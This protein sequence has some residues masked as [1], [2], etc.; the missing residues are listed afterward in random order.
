VVGCPIC[1]FYSWHIQGISFSFDLKV[2]PLEHFDMVLGYDWLIQ[3]RP[4]KV[5][6]GSKWLV[7]PYVCSTI[8]L[9]GL[10]SQL[11]AGDMVQLY[12]LTEQDLKLDNSDD[13]PSNQSVPIEVQSLLDRYAGV[14]ATQ[15]SYPP[16]RYCSH[17]IPLIDGVRPVH[18][19]PYRY[20]PM[21]K[22]EIEN[23][24]QDMLKQGLI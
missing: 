5:H 20:A 15:V 10:L 24:V 7:I 11:K 2:I 8:V 16:D 23:Q 13:G 1:L 12:Q 18:I 19:R 22:T 21:L 9:H 14:F 17:S 6:W 4:M 3:F